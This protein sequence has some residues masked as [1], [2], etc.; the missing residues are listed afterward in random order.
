MNTPR[1]NEVAKSFGLSPE[2]IALLKELVTLSEGSAKHVATA[3]SEELTPEQFT[4]ELDES[5]RIDAFV[6]KRLADTR[7]EIEKAFL[8]YFGW[9]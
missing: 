8:K 3:I 4:E 1:L 2:E 7:Q 5:D 9:I 6:A